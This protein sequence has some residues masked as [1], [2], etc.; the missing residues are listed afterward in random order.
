MQ[1]SG[2][3]YED[4]EKANRVMIKE[5]VNDLLTEAEKVNAKYE[6]AFHT[7]VSNISASPGQYGLSDVHIYDRDD[8][9]GSLEDALNSDTQNGRNWISLIKKRADFNKQQQA[10]A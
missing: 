1:L 8:I 5:Q 10:K 2:Q 9:L 3:A 7:A 6:L 4:A